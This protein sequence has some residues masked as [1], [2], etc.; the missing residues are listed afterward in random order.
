MPTAS[1][2]IEILEDSLSTVQH[3]LGTAQHV[4]HVADTTERTVRRARRSVRRGLIVVLV[5][6]I[7]GLL[8]YA[9][10]TRAQRTADLVVE[11]KPSGPEPSR[12]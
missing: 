7:I 4:L 8:V 2:T 9:L 11:K 12:P 5:A 10:R 6:A 3:G 1:Q